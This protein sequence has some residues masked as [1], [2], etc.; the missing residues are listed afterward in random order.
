[1]DTKN[2][3]IRS[4]SVEQT[5]MPLMSQITTLINHKNARLKRSAHSRKTLQDICMKLREAILYF[6]KIGEEIASENPE[7][8]ADMS[9]ACIEAKEAASMMSSLTDIPMNNE[10]DTAVTDRANII[11]AARAL[12]AAV[13]RVLIITDMVVVK[14]LITAARK[15][16][17]RL[18]ALE[19]VNNFTEFVQAFSHF[20]ADMVELAH[21]SGDRQNDLKDDISKAEMC[22]ARTLLEKSTMMLLTTSKT[23]LRHPD[24]GSAKQNREGVFLKMRSAMNT[25][26]SVAQSSA[27]RRE[28]RKGQLILDLKSFD[29]VVEKIKTKGD[30]NN[31]ELNKRLEEGLTRILEDSRTIAGAPH[32]KSEKRETIL[33]LCENA[34]DVL[35]DLT[36]TKEENDDKQ[37]LT[38]QRISKLTKDLKTE[39][40]QA[41]SDQVFETFSHLGHK[42]SLPAMRAAAST[43]NSARVDELAEVFVRDVKKL[44]EVSKVARN[45]SASEPIA[46]TAEKV[47]ENIETLC[48]HVIE[49]ARTL[50]HHPVSKIAQENCTVFIDIWESQVEELGK[51]LRSIISGGDL[52]R[53]ENKLTVEKD[54]FPSRIDQMLKRGLKRESPATSDSEDESEK[55][56]QQSSMEQEKLIKIIEDIESLTISSEMNGRDIDPLHEEAMRRAREMSTIAETMNK[57]LRGEGR[58]HSSEELFFEAQRFADVGRKF[59]KLST[60]FLLQLPDIL[61]KKQLAPYMDRIPGY[62]QQLNFASKS[63]AVGQSA[64]YI[65]AGSAIHLTRNILKIITRILKTFHNL[66]VEGSEPG[67]YCPSWTSDF[68]DVSSISSLSSTPFT[69]SL[70]PEPPPYPA[71]ISD[72]ESDIDSVHDQTL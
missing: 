4:K 17:E 63:F 32:T 24:S 39:V 65:K 44:L 66:T 10:G 35:Q 6:V 43:G 69:S 46:L 19:S 68:S 40:Q 54:T 56:S 9:K 59:H 60:Q 31:P 42:K 8:A 20:G 62:C 11:R 55:S 1:M 25:I 47:E 48:P 61:P 13:T 16:D 72:V 21:L 49:A 45:L 30:L 37:D 27:R 41:A 15:V 38:L 7:F 51:L 53:M 5:L 36:S 14:R 50:A 67:L 18:Q 29:H 58:I 28:P 71:S 22:A 70:T 52:R 34:E 64:T 2:L 57:F 33:A 23:F 12:L 3:E 26:T